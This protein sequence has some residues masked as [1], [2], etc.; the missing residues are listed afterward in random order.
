MP[1][2]EL[3]CFM[4]SAKFPCRF[5]PASPGRRP[6]CCGPWNSARCNRGRDA[7]GP[8]YRARSPF[9]ARRRPSG[10]RGQPS[11]QRQWPCGA[12][13]GGPQGPPT[14]TPRRYTTQYGQVGI[15]VRHRLAAHLYQ[16]DHGHQHPQ[17]PEPTH[18]QVGIFSPPDN[19]DGR[20]RRQQREGPDHLPRAPG[21]P[22][23]GD[24]RRPDSSD[25]GIFPG[26]RPGLPRR[27][28]PETAT[29]AARQPRWRPFAPGRSP[30]KTPPPKRTGESFPQNTSA[31]RP[32]FPA[33]S[34]PTATGRKERSPA[35]AW[36]R[37]PRHRQ[38]RPK[39]S[40]ATLGRRA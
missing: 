22:G 29:A 21:W 3:N 8:R 16:T 12:P 34:S 37:G 18:D 39:G 6:N 20:D 25:K 7:T 15:S 14:T 11:M 28:P 13:A 1:I 2:A 38:G 35:S 24:K 27:W 30:R 4:A 23:D 19:G 31:S 17:V 33:A 40:G 9:A 10:G 36:P 5:S 32:A 26:T